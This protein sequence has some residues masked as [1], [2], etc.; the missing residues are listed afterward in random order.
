MEI[1]KS[2]ANPSAA[3]ATSLIPTRGPRRATVVACSAGLVRDL[4][5]AC[6]S[7]RSEKATLEGRLASAEAAAAE[8]EARASGGT[9]LGGNR[10][11]SP[12]QEMEGDF[13]AGTRAGKKRRDGGKRGAVAGMGAAKVFGQLLALGVFGFLG[14]QSLEEGRKVS[15]DWRD[16]C[17][18]DCWWVVPLDRL[19]GAAEGGEG[20]PLER[21]RK[22]VGR[23]DGSRGSTHGV[24]WRRRGLKRA[25]SFFFIFVY[26]T[27]ACMWRWSE[28]CCL[29]FLRGA[30]VSARGT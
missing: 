5:S 29:Y 25:F 12:S 26:V 2:G 20:G 23:R 30:R 10:S 28:L 24:V 11:T 16:K 27:I 13:S 15:R 19:L 4:I 14:P 17:T 18:W 7:L 1:S 6:V 22:L 3:A 9:A 21:A 8:A